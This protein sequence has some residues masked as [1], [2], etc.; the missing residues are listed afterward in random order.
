MNSALSNTSTPVSEPATPSG[1]VLDPGASPLTLANGWLLSEPVTSMHFATTFLAS[2]NPAASIAESLG[3]LGLFINQINN[4]PYF[5]AV[6]KVIEALAK[7]LDGADFAGNERLQA[8]FFPKL[9]S[10]KNN[11]TAIHKS[12]RM[13][14]KLR[15]LDKF[16]SVFFPHLRIAVENL[17]SDQSGHKEKPLEVQTSQVYSRAENVI[18][19]TGRKS[20][21]IN[22][23]LDTLVW[24]ISLKKHQKTTDNGWL[25]NSHNPIS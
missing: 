12:N 5:Q 6:Q 14:L 25:L 24:K 1:F 16:L 4:P 13:Q 22:H 19:D 20:V 21:H 2:L 9:A 11:R 10:V 17:V 3:K 7:E 15:I 8:A 23:I 18:H